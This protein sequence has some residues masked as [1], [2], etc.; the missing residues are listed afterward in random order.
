MCL[1]SLIKTICNTI[2][3]KGWERSLHKNRHITNILIFIV[4][5]CTFLYPQIALMIR[6][7][8][9]N[10]LPKWLTRYFINNE[11]KSTVVICCFL[12]E[13]ENLRQLS[14]MD[15]VSVVCVVNSFCKWNLCGR[16]SDLILWSSWTLQPNP[17]IKQQDCDLLFFRWRGQGPVS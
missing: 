1:S 8:R 5:Y 4:L 10:V 9:R 3:F 6:I 14:S 17:K 13:R 7:Q 16:S 15:H 11:V 12:L 2:H